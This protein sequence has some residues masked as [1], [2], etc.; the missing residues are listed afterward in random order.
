MEREL[1]YI[2]DKKEECPICQKEFTYKHVKTG[3]A[4]FQGSDEDLRPRY[5]G[6]DTIKYDVLFCTHCGY[7]SVSREFTNVTSK[8]RQNILEGIA[9]KFVGVEHPE[10]IYTYDDAIYRYKMAVLTA[11]VKP[12]KLSE[13]AYLMLKLSWLYRGAYEELEQSEG[14]D[15][16]QLQAYKSG[17]EHYREEAFKGLEQALMTE[18][19]PICGMD[20]ATLN[21]LMSVL[22]YKSG[23]YDDAQR[24]SYMVLGSRQASAKLKEKQRVLV[25][26][27]KQE[28]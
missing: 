22:A 4:R 9:S 5:L 21:Y 15:E 11:M 16:A 13:A 25:E 12:A 14:S 27:I 1:S 10:G 7:A 2:L 17:E 19:P 6:I 24:Y 18:Y 26:K 20:E 23:K 28:K 3:K 8:Q